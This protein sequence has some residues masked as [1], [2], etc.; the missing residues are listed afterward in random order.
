VDFVELQDECSDH[1]GEFNEMVVR[2]N[3]G[4]TLN[5]EMTH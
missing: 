2:N 4:E 3:G 5:K 1:E